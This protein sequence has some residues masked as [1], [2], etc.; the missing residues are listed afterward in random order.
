MMLQEPSPLQSE[1][2]RAVSQ[3]LR[4]GGG[5]APVLLGRPRALPL[6]LMHLA[7]GNASDELWQSFSAVCDTYDGGSCSSFSGSRLD[8]LQRGDL[9]DGHWPITR[10]HHQMKIAVPT[11][12]HFFI[13]DE[14]H[15]VKAKDWQQEAAAAPY[16]MCVIGGCPIIAPVHVEDMKE[17]LS[18]VSSS[19]A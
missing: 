3:L 10:R 4:P 12:P 19:S 11:V 7:D 9:V 14:V 18:L 8:Q 1:A 16:Q 17:V 5:T 2:E 6:L 13:P 15:R